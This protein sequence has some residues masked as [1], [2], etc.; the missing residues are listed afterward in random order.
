MNPA[1]LF[2]EPRLRHLSVLLNITVLE[3]TWQGI[4]EMQTVLE[5]SGHVISMDPQIAEHL[6]KKLQQGAITSCTVGLCYTYFEHK[7]CSKSFVHRRRNN[8]GNFK[9]LLF[10][11]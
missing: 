5:N 4:F 6:L 2:H 10:S 9:G 7:N 3:R 8:L 11:H 1:A